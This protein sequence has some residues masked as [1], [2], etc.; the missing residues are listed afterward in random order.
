MPRGFADV[1]EDVESAGGKL[2]LWFS[3]SAVYPNSTDYQWAADNGYVVSEYDYRRPR[4]H[5]GLSLADPKYRQ[6]T[7]QQL[8]KLIRENGLAQ[9]KYDGLIAQ[10]SD[11]HHDL[12]SGKDSVE[13]LAHHSFELLDA[14]REANPRVN[15]EPTYLNSHSNYISPWIIRHAD[16][17]WGNAGGDCPRGFTPAPDY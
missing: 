5:P 3:P 4:R 7:I 11:P 17:V 15:T 16:S 13:P 8:Q 6:D 1:R 2:G 14:S 12:L 9:I 10:E